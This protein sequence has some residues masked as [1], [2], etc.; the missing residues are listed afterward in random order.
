[1]YGDVIEETDWSVGEILKAIDAAGLAK[2]TLVV[3]TCDN[4]PWL[5]YGNHAGTAG[6]LR[7]GEG[8]VWEG[9]VRVPF[10]ARWPGTDRGRERVPHP[11]DDD[12]H[13]AHGRE[14]T[15]PPTC[16]RTRSTGRTYR[17]CSK[18]SRPPTSRTVLFFYYHVNELHAGPRP[19]VEADP[20]AH[21]PHDA[22]AA[23]G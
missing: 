20:A 8:T 16:R 15:P 23:G 18:P 12:R 14:A 7:E 2:D 21:L 5:S 1:M 10:L 17:S 3:F 6:P 22:G 19:P 13:P 11:G 9:G 4:G